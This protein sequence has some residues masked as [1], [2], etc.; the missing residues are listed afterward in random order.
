MLCKFRVLFVSSYCLDM[1]LKTCSKTS[2]CPCIFIGKCQYEVFW[3]QMMSYHDPCF[4]A[5]VCKG[6]P[7]LFVFC[8]VFISHSLAHG[9]EPF[10]RSRQLCSHSRTSQHFMEPEDS[11]PCSQE[12]STGL[13]REP[14]QS[15]PSQPISKT[16]QPRPCT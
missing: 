7:F 4:F 11:L 12:P 13:Y 14:D 6:S 5:S 15:N 16:R 9:A 2:A 10:L 1:F 3:L 8:G